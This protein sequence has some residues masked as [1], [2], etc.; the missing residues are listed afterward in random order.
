MRRAAVVFPVQGSP[1][2]KNSV[3]GLTTL[4]ER[5]PYHC[6]RART[7]EQSAAAVGLGE[8]ERALEHNPEWDVVSGSRF[9]R[10]LPA[11]G[12]PPERVREAVEP[13]R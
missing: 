4:S 9:G 12:D 11:Q 8:G 3:G 10:Q 13:L 7:G 2:V 6:P 1:T 5:T